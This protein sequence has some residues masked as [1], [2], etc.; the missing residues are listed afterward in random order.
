[1]EIAHLPSILVSASMRLHGL[2]ISGAAFL[3]HRLRQRPCEWCAILSGAAFLVHR[4]GSE[5]VEGRR[6]E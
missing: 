3:V 6:L 5:F 2:H 1:M 4:L